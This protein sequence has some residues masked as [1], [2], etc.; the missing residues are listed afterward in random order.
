MGAAP[1]V[2]IIKKSEAFASDFFVFTL[3]VECSGASQHLYPVACAY[4]GLFAFDGCDTRKYFTLDGFEQCA[5]AGRDVR[6]LV[7]HA[8]FV[9]AGNRVAAT[10][11]G[12]GAVLGSFGNSL[13][14][15]A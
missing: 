8:E 11:E 3:G 4:V 2:A 15:S 14:D 1:A 6:Y 5:A 9:D 10:D 13:G 12:E 7:G